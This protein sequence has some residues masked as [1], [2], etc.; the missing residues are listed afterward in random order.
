MRSEAVRGEAVRGEA[1][2]GEAVRLLRRL[3]VASDR[4]DR[5]RSERASDA[6]GV[7]RGD[8]DEVRALLGPAADRIARL[9]ELAGALADGTLTEASAGEAAR[10]VAT[11]Q[12]HRGVR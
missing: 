12:P 2:R 6:A 7:D 10:A 1:V 4:L 3:E 8:D 5:A 9:A 11:S